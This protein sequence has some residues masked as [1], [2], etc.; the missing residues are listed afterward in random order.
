MRPSKSHLL[1]KFL[2]VSIV[3]AFVLP[4]HGENP[5]P[6]TQHQEPAYRVSKAKKIKHEHNQPRAPHPLDP[7]LRLAYDALDHMENNLVDYTA[8]L[9]KRERVE[10]VLLDH[11]YMFVKVRHEKKDANGGI[12]VP[13][14]VY[15]KFVGPR[16]IKGRE[17]MWVRGENEGK[18]VAHEGRGPLRVFGSVWL[19][20]EGPIAM[21]GQRYPITEIGVKTLAVRLIEKG[22]RDAKQPP[23]E[24][25]FYYNAVVDGRKCTC[26]EVKHKEKC[27][28]FDF[29][30]ARVFVDDE[31]KI[32]IRYAAWVWP[33]EP[34]GKPVLIEEYTY[35]KI[36]VNPG[37]K[38]IDFDEK[39]SEY[40]F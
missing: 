12:L 34:G 4:S 26:L 39:N 32:P 16:A 5:L 2:A 3:A 40:G 6:R 8:T 19:K 21:R 37:L 36:K 35:T 10:G 7:A 33:R 31:L 30:R 1:S 14:S 28:P 20:P 9:V 38:D 17:V 25:N 11:E 18:L 27:D 13:F 15:L 29:C 24:V 22:E 23:C